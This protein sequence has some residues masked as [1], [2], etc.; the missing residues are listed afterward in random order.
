MA[1]STTHSDHLRGITSE[2]H[3][4]VRHALAQLREPSGRINFYVAHHAHHID[5]LPEEEEYGIVR[6][7]LAAT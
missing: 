4:M 7:L 3:F 2:T 6:M 1:Q 5:G